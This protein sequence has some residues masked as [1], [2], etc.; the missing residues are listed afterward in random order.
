M[1]INRNQFNHR[2]SSASPKKKWANV[3]T[4]EGSIIHVRSQRNADRVVLAIHGNVPS[5]RVNGII[6]PPRPKRFH[7]F[8]APGW[9]RIMLRGSAM[10]VD[11]GT[12]AP[13]QLIATDMTYRSPLEAN[14][15]IRTR[16]VSNAIRSDDGDVTITQR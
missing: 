4:R 8:M 12:T 3:D 6:P 11:V 10:D 7:S 15:L 14:L 2:L 9:I 5:L 1:L 16:N 13:L